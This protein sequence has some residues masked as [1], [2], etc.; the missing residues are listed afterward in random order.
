MEVNG[1]KWNSSNVLTLLSIQ[2]QLNNDY[3][4]PT[5]KTDQESMKES[6]KNQ[7]NKQNSYSTHG[8]ELVPRIPYKLCIQQM[9]RLMVSLVES[10]KWRL[11]S[12]VPNTK[13]TKPLMFI[14]KEDSFLKAGL[15]LA[16]KGAVICVLSKSSHLTILLIWSRW[17]LALTSMLGLVELVLDWLW[18]DDI[19]AKSKLLPLPHSYSFISITEAKSQRARL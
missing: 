3:F 19:F 10:N 8:V 15:D 12:I 16:W 7:S 5:Q 6:I 2:Q 11:P 9:V 13:R 18:R 4:F 14:C 1:W 17:E